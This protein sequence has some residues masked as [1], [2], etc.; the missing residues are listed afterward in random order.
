M[1]F[2]L[3]DKPQTRAQLR[4]L[5]DY[6]RPW[7]QIIRS[8]FNTAYYVDGF[9]GAGA[10]RYG[11]VEVVGSPGIAAKVGE[12]A[13]EEARAKGRAFEL[14]CRLVEADP[15]TCESLRR[16]TAG[17][18]HGR[19]EVLCEPFAEAIEGILKEIAQERRG[20]RVAAFFF[21]DPF[22]LN[23]PLEVAQRI[24]R[25][26]NTECLLNLCVPGIRRVAGVVQSG[27]RSEE[28][29][30]RL[31]ATLATVY[32]DDSWRRA[33]PRRTAAERETALVEAYRRKLPARYVTAHLV[34]R[35]PYHHLMYYLIHAANNPTGAGIMGDL[36]TREETAGTL[37]APA[38]VGDLRS[39]VL[40]RF[41]GKTVRKPD[42]L[43]AMGERTDTRLR[44][45]LGELL[46]D[47]FAAAPTWGLDENEVY[48]FF[49]KRVT[50]HRR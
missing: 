25:L 1:W 46:V 39:R 31:E 26:P 5:A 10:Y 24:V 27:P 32:G 30:R 11:G 38:D 12:S 7:S 3:D 18:G 33:W 43:A 44:R 40:E 42:I 37:F 6:L 23:V 22:G 20:Q 17:W 21:V 16:A 14:R 28:A 50:G 36:F 15:A 8:H 45:P 41:R 2:T 13:A 9:A 4:I 34:L 29:A 19:I 48:T 35:S 49:P 47:G